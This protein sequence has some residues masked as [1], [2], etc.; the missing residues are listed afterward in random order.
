MIL[1]IYICEFIY[2]LLKY[3]NKNARDRT[4]QH[5]LSWVYF[6]KNIQKSPMIVMGHALEPICCSATGAGP[7]AFLPIELK[8]K[9]PA[10]IR[11]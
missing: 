2:G 9:F 5:T 6:L 3:Q 8:S 1:W 4:T 11:S 10:P 7:V